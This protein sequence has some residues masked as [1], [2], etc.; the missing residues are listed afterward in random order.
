MKTNE[1]HITKNLKVL[2]D[3]FD[4]LAD[5]CR[6]L[7]INR[8]QFNKYLAGLHQ[9]SQKILLK[10]SRYFSM[11]PEDLFLEPQAF[12]NFYEGKEYEIPI[13]L[14]DNPELTKFLSLA[15]DSSKNLDGIL[16][17]YFRYHNSSIYKGRIL[18]SITHIYKKGKFIQHTTTERF[19]KLD[20]SG[21][22]GYT[23]SYHGFCFLFGDRIFLVDFEGDQ[24][25]EMTFSILVPQHRKPLRFVY[26]TLSG[27]A[28]TTFRQPFS[29]RMILEFVGKEKPAK[30]LLEKA[31]ALLPTDNSIPLE[32]REYLT[33]QKNDFIFG[34]EF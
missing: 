30:S 11:E 5:F 33:N 2:A 23:F 22:I 13:D 3:S 18:R 14:K 6:K 31:T 16:G 17:T 12:I 24:K 10:I 32:V 29:T 15:E 20:G 8:Q 9:P 26:G 19:P 1:A 21:K 28:A 25:N 27:I 4:S 7:G 34:G